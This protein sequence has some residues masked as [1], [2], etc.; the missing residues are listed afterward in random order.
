[1]SINISAISGAGILAFGVHEQEI[2]LTMK[3][4]K[5]AYGF[6][7]VLVALLAAG[8]FFKDR[9]LTSILFRDF[10]PREPKNQVETVSSIGWWAYQKELKVDAFT[11]KVIE[12]KLSLFNSYSL[13]SYTV[14]GELKGNTNWKPYIGNVHI[15]QRFLRAY[16]RELHP[17]L[18]RD[19][20]SIPEAIIEITPLVM[21]IED[22]GYKGEPVRF[23]FTNEL[24][25]QSFHYGDCWIR[26][27]CES[28]QKDVILKQVK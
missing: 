28:S 16:N 4:R 25:I 3:S 18:E 17:Y 19:T 8:L 11:V 21:T 14:K 23:E 22:D 7:I 6:V 24:K 9:I 10:S 27:K 15:S 26:F 12:S 20:S 2:K 13:I 1:M 5:V